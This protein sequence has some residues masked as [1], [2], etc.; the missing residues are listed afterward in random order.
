MENIQLFNDSR[1]IEYADEVA[2]FRLPRWEQ[3][4]TL[5]LYMDQVVTV[6]DQALNPL[7]GF[8]E[9]A[10]ITPSMI[11]NYVK[12]GMVKKPEKKKYSREHIAALIVITILKQSAAIGDIRMGIDTA[13]KSGDKQSSYDS[14]CDYVERA[15]RI[16]A[17]CA[18]STDENVEMNVR[19]NSEHALITMAACSFAT[20]IVTAKMV[21]IIRENNREQTE[22][23]DE[24]DTKQ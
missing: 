19:F 12:L 14:F 18:V 2:K 11:N 15:V 21:S 20:I 7:I 5:G 23:T 10:I 17:K 3:I 4:P 1:M 16:V 22:N 24:Q 13:L 6:I 8:D 9:D